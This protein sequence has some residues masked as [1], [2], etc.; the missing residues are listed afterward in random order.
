MRGAKR[1]AT[2]HH[3]PKEENVMTTYRKLAIAAASLVGVLAAPGTALADTTVSLT[4]GPIP[5]GGVPAEICVIQSDVEAEECEST[6]AGETVSLTVVAEVD[7]PEPVLVPPTVTP[8]PCPAGTE[9]VAAQ[10][11]TGSAATTISGSVTVVLDDGAP[12]V[13]PIEEVVAAGGQTVTVFACAGASPGVPVP[14]PP[15][16]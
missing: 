10:V 4:V 14:A 2:H 3:L 8:V 7:T 11:S 13:V 15:V 1:G 9:G 12:V 16:L 6:P 5:I